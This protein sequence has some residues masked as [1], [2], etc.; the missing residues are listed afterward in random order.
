V[1]SFERRVR[2]L[3]QALPPTGE[4]LSAQLMNCLSDLELQALL[5][6]LATIQQLP[7]SRGAQAKVLLSA[8]LRRRA[9]GVRWHE[10]M[11]ATETYVATVSEARPP[12]RHKTSHTQKGETRGSQ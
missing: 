11:K 4:A 7:E 8:G 1:I 10:S 12:I 3:E 5:A 2:R 6:L 9:Q